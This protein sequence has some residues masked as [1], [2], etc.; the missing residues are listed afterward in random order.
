M[1]PKHNAKWGLD[2]AHLIARKDA[3]IGDYAA[4]PF[5]NWGTSCLEYAVPKPFSPDFK[6]YNDSLNEVLNN[7]LV[8]L[9]KSPAESVKQFGKLL[10]EKGIPANKLK[11]M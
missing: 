3:L 7:Y 1:E 8:E 9:G 10:V 6:R 2:T 4:H 5:M 11:D